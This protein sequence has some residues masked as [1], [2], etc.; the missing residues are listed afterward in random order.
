LGYKFPRTLGFAASRCIISE[1]S[2]ASRFRQ[3]SPTPRQS[4]LGLYF[5]RR[6]MLAIVRMTFIV[7][8]FVPMVNTAVV[9]LAY[10]CKTLSLT[11]PAICFYQQR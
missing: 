4:S 11:L 1:S 5:S 8:N 7:I 6:R 2:P 3:R 10:N 9:Y